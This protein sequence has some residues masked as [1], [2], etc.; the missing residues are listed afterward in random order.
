MA[1]SIRTTE[2]TSRSSVLNTALGASAR[3]RLY[4]GSA[5]ASVNNAAT[6]TLLAECICNATQFG[7][8]SSG[9]LTASAVAGET[10]VARDNAANATD[11]VGYA[12]L[13]NS[14]GTD[15]IQFSTVGT[16]GSGQEVIM[17]SLSINT[18]EPVEVTSIVITEGNG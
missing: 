15:I 6:G 5:P 1:M 14:S 10:Y 13:A 7:T 11:T 18:G 9:V 12:R 3:V 16:T 2:R 17:P 8:V 4:S